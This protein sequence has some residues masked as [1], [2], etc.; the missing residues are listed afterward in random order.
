MLVP[1]SL[2]VRWSVTAFH[3]TDT[4]SNTLISRG[5]GASASTLVDIMPPEKVIFS[6]LKLTCG[7]LDSPMKTPSSGSQSGGSTL[8][9]TH[10]VIFSGTALVVAG[11]VGQEWLI[12]RA[13]SP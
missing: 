12:G 10:A 9:C 11:S 3:F 6:D 2:M 7:R 8:M 5:R 13:L 1:E 4:F